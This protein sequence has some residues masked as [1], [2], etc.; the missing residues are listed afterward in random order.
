M[1][2]VEMKTLMI[3]CLTFIGQSLM[4]ETHNSGLGSNGSINRPAASQN[5]NA[6]LFELTSACLEGRSF[7]GLSTGVDQ[8]IASPNF[9]GIDNG[10]V[11]AQIPES[12]LTTPPLP[13]EDDSVLA[14][15]NTGSGKAALGETLAGKCK[16]CHGG[17]IPGDRQRRLG[18]L[19]GVNVPEAANMRAYL[20]GL[21]AD[22]KANLAAFFNTQP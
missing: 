3:I 11:N 12:D 22:D 14:E 21:S 6:R 15:G 9:A 17:E 16:S 13:P 20:A 19:Q 7:P 2:W 8:G 5:A 18:I 10:G 4:A 1:K